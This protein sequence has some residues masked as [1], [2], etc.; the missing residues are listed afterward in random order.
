VV[1]LGNLATRGSSTFL[2]AF[3]ADNRCSLTNVQLRTYARFRLQCPV[4]RA[5]PCAN[6]SCSRH[7]DAHGRHAMACTGKATV[8]HDST[9]NLLME[10]FCAYSLSAS[11]RPSGHRFAHIPDL[12]VDSTIQPGKTWLEFYIPDP[13]LDT[14]MQ[15]ADRSHKA[16]N[17][18]RLYRAKLHTEYRLPPK[19]ESL[20]TCCRWSGLFTAT[21]FQIPWPPSAPWPAARPER[22]AALPPSWLIGGTPWPTS[23]SLRKSL[24]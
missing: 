5:G 21:P 18:A 22:R 16:P 8:R 19:R 11:N 4:M 12:E 3:P 14:R 23:T 1:L 9:Q 20:T 2:T 7:A 13:S 17:L 24:G 10:D 15:P 6:N